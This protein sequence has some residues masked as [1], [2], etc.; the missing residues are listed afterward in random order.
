MTFGSWPGAMAF[1]PDGDAASLVRDTLTTPLGP[2]RCLLLISGEAA[3]YSGWSA[4]AA[5]AL[6]NALAAGGRVVLADLHIEQPELDGLVS[7]RGAEGV[8]DAILFGAS[9][10]H[11]ALAST[12]H[13]FE[14]L[15]A[16]GPVP[17]PEAVLQS[18]EWTRLLKEAERAGLTLLLYAPWRAR[19]LD[20]LVK[21]VGAAVMLA[22]ATDA[23]LAAGYLPPDIEIRAILAPATQRGIGTPAATAPREREIAL[24]AKRRTHRW[25]RV[26]IPVLIIVLGAGAAAVLLRQPVTPAAE[27]AAPPPPPPPAA[28]GEPA[29]TALPYAVAIE[30]H[31]DLRTADERVTAL[32]TAVPSTGFFLAP[33]LVDSVLFYRVLAG[34][35][36]DSANAA[37]LMTALIATGHKTGGT[38]FDIRHVP[39]AFSL[40]EY[41]TREAAE[42]RAAQL[43]ALNIPAY[44]L[45]LP[46]SS[47]GERYALYCGAYAGPAEADAM[48]QVLAD[49]EIPATLVQRTGRSTS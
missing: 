12:D 36:S 24:P 3:R 22:G 9:L 30:A 46:Y 15:P 48:R 33:I 29:G 41:D 4:R 27:P 49:A 45:A 1:D 31:Q 37:A 42:T 2:P 5:I 25:L 40:G 28:I 32:R 20:A 8:A 10:E 23:R 19:G 39:L 44:V 16:G 43:A 14:L 35:V 18:P 47:G 38:E 26:A 21:R 11:L 17:D 6:A 7:T 13:R 34:P